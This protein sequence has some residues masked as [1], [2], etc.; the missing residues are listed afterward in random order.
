MSNLEYSNVKPI[1]NLIESFHRLPGIGP[2]MAQRLTYY[3]VRMSIKEA[4]TLANAIR[5]LKEKVIY[6]SSCHNISDI[7]PC[8]IC[9]DTTR[10]SSIICVVEDPLDVVAIES[11][12]VFKGIYH[13]LHGVIAPMK[14]IGPEDI[15]LHDLVD[16]INQGNVKELV[17]AT[18]PNVE[19]D[20]TTAYIQDLV[21]S[22]DLKITRLARGLPMGG[23]LEYADFVTLSRAIEGRQVL[24]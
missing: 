17:L 13:V 10:D 22:L 24:G 8:S 12:T 3:L 11:S 21:V 23:D 14:G 2:K 9:Q 6:C 5:D 18:N 19:G 16:R 15:K 20:A 1:N 7:N 4:E